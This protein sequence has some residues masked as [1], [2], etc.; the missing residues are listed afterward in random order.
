MSR[1]TP[2]RRRELRIINPNV[3]AARPVVGELVSYAD[4]VDQLPGVD[5]ARRLKAPQ[6]IDD[7]TVQ[8]AIE[9]VDYKMVT[10]DGIRL[11][12]QIDDWADEDHSSRHPDTPAG[13]ARPGRRPTVTWRALLV[14][15][16]L[17]GECDYPDLAVDLAKT[18]WDRIPARFRDDLGIAPVGWGCTAAGCLGGRCRHIID[19]LATR[20]R[21]Q[22]RT[23]TDLMDPYGDHSGRRLA[24]DDAADARRSYQ[25]GEQERLAERLSVTANAILGATRG[26]T[27][28]ALMDGWDGEYTLDGTRLRSWARGP[29][30][31]SRADRVPGQDP[32]IVTSADP[33]AGWDKDQNWGHEVVLVATAASDNDDGILYRPA[34]VLGMS[35]FTPPGADLAALTVQALDNLAARGLPPKRIVNDRGFTMLTSASYQTPLTASYGTE[36]VHDYPRHLLGPRGHSRGV[37]FIEGSLYC[38][39]TPH[40]LAYASV[41]F[42][43]GDEHGN[44]IDLAEYQARLAARSEYR[45]KPK[46]LKRNR[47]RCPAAGRHC[48]ARC[49]NRPETLTI[50]NAAKPRVYPTVNTAQTGTDGQPVLPDACTRGDIT[51]NPDDDAELV[52]LLLRYGQTH[53]WMTPPWFAAY[54]QPRS[55]IEGF[56]GFVKD[57]AKEALAT[58]GRRRMLGGAIGTLFAAFR[59]LA[60]NIRKIVGFLNSGLC[61]RKPNGE[62]AIIRLSKADLQ[63]AVSVAI[64]QDR[65]QPGPDPPGPGP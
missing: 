34:L 40:H 16:V 8:R 6:L 21:Y 24:P 15:L 58:A 4:V 1:Y 54:Q 26:I 38:A 35:I 41:H 53:E 22:L 18:L 63:A 64:D 36:F 51:I 19:R 47:W 28:P 20:V 10:P 42:F 30:Y 25:P 56:N 49:S 3:A 33:S 9:I 61:L 13:A 31:T 59:L 48:T 37:V 2:K 32:M 43:L 55:T 27:P 5:Q 50:R 44:R 45:F 7:A 57:E 12:D 46:D 29:R 23:L 39:D 11:C 65:Y 60:A 62:I 52:E 17:H 14:G